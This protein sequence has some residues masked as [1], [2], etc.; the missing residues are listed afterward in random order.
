M[1]GSAVIGSL[2]VG[3]G[4][5]SAQFTSG[6]KKSEN[7]LAGFGKTVANSMAGI[8]VAA[9]AALA[10]VSVAIGKTISTADEMT[11]SAQKFGVPVDQLSRLK[12]AADLSGV[13][14]DT[15][16]T[17]LRRLSDT[18]LQVSAGAS[19]S[20]TR[21][22]EALDVTVQNSDGSLRSSSDVMTDIAGKLSQMQDGAAKT[23]A[24]MAIFGRSGADLIPML[25]AGRDGLAA[26]LAEADALGITLDRNTGQAAERFNDNLTRLGKITDGFTL[27]LTAAMLPALEKASEAFLAIANDGEKVQAIASGLT[28]A[29]AFVSNEIAQLAIIG[30]RLSAEFAGISEA[31]GRLKSGDF[32][33]AWSAWLAGQEQSVKMSEDLRKQIDGIFSGE[34]FSQGQIQRRIDD[35]FGQSGASAGASFVARF[36]EASKTVGDTVTKTDAWKGLRQAAEAASSAVNGVR[37]AVDSFVSDMRSGLEAGEG[38]W[39]SFGSAAMKAIDR[40]VDAL[41]NDVLDAMFKVNT[42]GSGG[43]FLGAI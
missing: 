28:R 14:I 36:A 9:S 24:A 37:Y 18:M 17:G 6:L 33:G 13:S 41:L 10:G 26:M 22:L 42:A 34:V 3:L 2:R 40:L 29:F 7:R 25:N 15:L 4:L 16:G 31:F 32:R 21:A 27:K 30:N 19:T 43:G 38:F 5:D 39:K 12:H 23:A 8:A 35:A 20:A 11:K 1:A